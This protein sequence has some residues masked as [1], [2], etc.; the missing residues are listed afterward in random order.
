M[1]VFSACC[2]HKDETGTDE[3]AHVL[4]ELKH[5][6]THQQKK[7]KKKKK[8]TN[9]NNNNNNNNKKQ[10][11]PFTFS[12]LRLEPLATGFIIQRISHQATN[13][14][15]LEGNYSQHCLYQ[16]HNHLAPE[17]DSNNWALYTNKSKPTNVPKGLSDS[18][19]PANQHAQQPSVLSD[20][21]LSELRGATTAS[22]K[23]QQ[24]QQAA[25]NSSK[26]QAAATA[27]SNT[28]KQQL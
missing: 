11:Q 12:G 25:S 28:S 27:A 8:K 26:Q 2:A 1:A 20:S 24:Q 5:T 18:P 23:Q 9:N 21:W 10:Q 4:E 17:G 7:K 15:L 13:S 14:F 19:Q 22:S 16:Y 6:H 3:T